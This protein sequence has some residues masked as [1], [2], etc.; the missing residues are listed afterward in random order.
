LARRFA[1][2]RARLDRLGEMGHRARLAQRLADEQPARAGLDRHVNLALPEP[3][4]PATHGVRIR[5]D[6]T[7]G[8]L[9]RSR[10]NAS[11]VI[12]AL[13]T[14]NPATIAIGASSKAPQ[15]QIRASVS[16]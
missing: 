6:P 4:Y 16:R 10:S 7:A 12:C 11:K 13:C 8:L 5:R 1:P 14:S 3:L 2:Q 15:L 9:A